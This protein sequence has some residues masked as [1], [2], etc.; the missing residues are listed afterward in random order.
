[1][2]ARPTAAARFWP[3]RRSCSPVAIFQAGGTWLGVTREGR[4][5]A[6]TNVREPGVAPLP[7]RPSRGRLVVNSCAERWHPGPVAGLDAGAYAG[8][9]LV[10]GDMDTLWHLSNRSGG[11]R[12]LPP[13]VHGVS[14]AGLGTPWPKVRRGRERLGELVSAGAATPEA[15]LGLLADEVVAGDAELPDTGVGLELERLLSSLFIAG[16]GYGTCSSTALVCQ[17][18]AGRVLRAN[19]AAGVGRGSG[20]GDRVRSRLSRC[21]VRT[22]RPRR[23]ISGEEEARGR[24]TQLDPA[25]S[26]GPA[27]GD[28]QVWRTRL[29]SGSHAGKLWITGG[30]SQVLAATQKSV[31]VAS[32]W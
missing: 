32:G 31:T 3:R 4:F 30:V 18:R 15:L 27:S 9:N 16:P 12:P 20:R 21:Q 19:D 6:L 26:T 29:A 5:A 10:V 22:V 14:N 24:W 8:F 25:A 2:R 1:M 23:A 11:P 13:G 28:P 17:R 7:G